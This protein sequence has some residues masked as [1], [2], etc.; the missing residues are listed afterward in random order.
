MAYG[1]LGGG[2]SG[3]TLLT[4]SEICS[5][6]AKAK[7]DNMSPQDRIAETMK[8]RLSGAVSTIVKN[9]PELTEAQKELLRTLVAPTEGR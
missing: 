2:K 3:F 4:R 6:A 9:W 5:K 8:G 7:W 1:H